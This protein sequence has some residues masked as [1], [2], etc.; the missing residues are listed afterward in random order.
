MAARS[1]A[2]RLPEAAASIAAVHEA[3][4]RLLIRGFESWG[5]KP[6]DEAGP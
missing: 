2:L 6:P 1:R 3:E 4:T 5:A